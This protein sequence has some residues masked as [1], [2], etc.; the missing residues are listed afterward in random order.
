MKNIYKYICILFACIAA[1]PSCQDKFEEE[2]EVLAL[3]Y[4]KIDVKHEGGKYTFMVYCSGD[5]TITLDK[6]VDWA[7]FD[8]TSGSG[9]TMVTIDFGKNEALKRSFNMTVSDGVE[10]LVIPVVQVSPIAKVVMEFLNQEGIGLADC[11][12]TVV[13]KLKSNLPPSFIET[14]V[15]QTDSKWIE[16]CK[17]ANG[18]GEDESVYDI[19]FKVPANDTGAERKAT[20]SLQFTDPDEVE[21][22]TELLVRQSNEPGILILDES[23]VYGPEEKECFE[24]VKGGLL[25]FTEIAG[26]VKCTV[27]DEEFVKNVRVDGGMLCYT[28]LENL[29]ESSREA[30]ITLDY[31]NVSAKIKIVQMD[32][33]VGSVIEITTA[34]ELLAWNNNVKSWRPHDRVILKSDID[35]KGVITSDDWTPNQF[36]GVFHGNGKTIDNLVVEKEGHAAF[37]RKLQGATVQ[38]LTFGEGCSFTSTAPEGDVVYA[39]S[40]AGEVRGGVTITNV[41]NYGDVNIPQDAESGVKGDYLGG[42]CAYFLADSDSQMT[43]CKNYG[44]LTYSAKAAG[45]VYC[46]GIAALAATKVGLTMSGCENHGTVLFD[47]V[48]HTKVDVNLGGI[49]AIANTVNF[50][51]CVNLGAV[52]SSTSTTVTGATN[53]GGI[54]GFMNNACGTIQNCVNGSSADASK[55]TLTND[56]PAS[57]VV[58]IGGFVGSV[59]SKPI[60]VTGF[61]NYGPV[62]NNGAVSNWTALGGVVGNIGGIADVNTVSDCENHGEVSNTNVVGRVSLGG[63]VGLIQKA[64]TAVTG[65]RNA[66]KVT[67]TGDA[68]AG[69]G[70][71]LGGI[72]GRI[73]AAPDGENTIKDNTNCGEIH[74]DANSAYDAG[75]SSGT[76]GILGVHAGEAYKV[77]EYGKTKYYHKSAKLTISG[78]TNEG[79]VK[80]TKEG[81]NYMNVG[82]IVAFLNGD[83]DPG[84]DHIHSAHVIDCTNN[85][86]VINEATGSGDWNSYIGGIVGNHHVKGE[87]KGCI[88][89]GAVINRTEIASTTFVR[90]R[91]G[92]IV[93]SAENRKLL[94]CFN[95]AEVKDDSKSNAGCVGGV[96]GCILTREM[97]ITG[98][99]NTG[100]V[101]GKFDASDKPSTV[102]LGGLLGYSA[103][104]ATLS[105]CSNSGTVTKGNAKASE[106]HIAGIAAYLN[107]DNNSASAVTNCT[108]SAE[109]AILNE[110]SEVSGAVYAGGIIGYHKIIGKVTGCKNK[111][112]VVNTSKASVNVAIGGITAR[113][114]NGTMTDCVN[115]GVVKD[116]SESKTGM[117][118]GI[119]G[120]VDS[121]DMTMTNCDNSGEI[122]GKFNSGDKDAV[123]IA[124]AIAY[125]QKTVSLDGCDMTGN[126]YCNRETTASHVYMGGLVAELPKGKE[127]KVVLKNCNVSGTIQNKDTTV[128]TK[129]GIGGFVGFCCSN[130]INNCHTKA[131]ITNASTANVYV[132]GFVGQIE[133]FDPISTD[134]TN[135][136]VNSNI[137]P[138]MTDYAGMLVG[139]LTYS[140][141]KTKLLNMQNIAVV[142]GIYNKTEL[143]TDNYSG[144]CYGQK[145]AGA[146]HYKPLDNVYFGKFQIPT[147]N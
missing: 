12:G 134:I 92:G 70:V 36:S 45:T 139:R 144:F 72:V 142:D 85:A 89:N 90:L 55:G 30:Y 61:K 22:K 49:A 103:I 57:G 53:I 28:L 25:N 138:N 110:A 133:G 67:N 10:T 73:E 3:D 34:E 113:A 127:P 62:T 13:V 121:R 132:G 99:M 95:N 111:A 126:L 51:S 15:P 54:V 88:N 63:V 107:G 9:V 17:I 140:P 123:K 32:A 68:P 86:E 31:E 77:D 29:T 58:R 79:T 42:I 44:G 82:G 24:I 59:I 87:L 106:I 128:E 64:N 129:T 119:A 65:N 5:W 131:S 8:T 81:C 48:N 38:D 118:A 136:S 145:T 26:K 84:N 146:S 43:G 93:G 116:D 124:G 71:A 18:S 98:C 60:N 104:S 16:D 7:T 100:Q 2:Y 141:A 91:I 122:S 147:S 47:G 66:G 137:S 94:N 75:M 80:K 52:K 108:N 83:Q 21:Y 120:Y 102:C 78:C 35:C 4:D 76:G 117:V 114:G 97:K 39:A 37:F 33:S 23:V 14:L 41:V 46:G 1:M 135:C 6:E 27:S 20:V 130:E 74:F 96:V 69:I 19:S 50:D 109:G 11:A 56:S 112:S 115:E 105:D 143:D 125:A 101:S 40:L